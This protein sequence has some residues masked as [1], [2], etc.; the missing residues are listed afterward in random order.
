MKKRRLSLQF[1]KIKTI[2]GIIQIR[3]RGV[4]FIDIPRT[5]S[6][7]IKAELGRLY[8]STYAKLNIADKHYGA[9]AIFPDH[10][11]AYK[12]RKILGHKLWEGIFTFTFI[13]NPWDRMLSLYFHR[14]DIAKKIPQ[15]MSFRDYI[16]QFNSPRYNCKISP[17]YRHQF[18]YGA[19]EFILDDNDNI[20]VDFIGRYENRAEDIK[21]IGSKIDCPDFGSLHLQKA[22][23]SNRHYSEYY[24]KETSDIISRVFRKDIELFGYSFE[25]HT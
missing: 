13:R 22:N 9:R 18:H 14:K 1:K 10:L 2:Y 24:D 7:S 23:K 15:N 16:L 20:I 25:H 4:W 5:S 8:G 3:R 11:T 6:S 19:S 12:M 21:K 17:F